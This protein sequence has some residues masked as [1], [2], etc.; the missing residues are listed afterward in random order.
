M[1]SNPRTRMVYPHFRS[2]QQR[3]CM[4]QYPSDIDL[5]RRGARHAKA[6][7]KIVSR[8]RPNATK[9]RTIISRNQPRE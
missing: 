2:S 7:R 1:F 5:C 8:S 9:A 6:R 3:V 4:T